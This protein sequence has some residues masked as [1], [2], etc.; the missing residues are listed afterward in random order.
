MDDFSCTFRTTLCRLTAEHY[1]TREQARLSI[2]EYLAYYNTERL[3]S[4]LNYVS[5]SEFERRWRAG[6][7]RKEERAS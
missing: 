7:E 3:H 4:S 2:T 6:N 5:P 1:A